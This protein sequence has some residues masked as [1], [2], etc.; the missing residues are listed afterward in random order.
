M[1]WDIAFKASLIICVGTILLLI[2]HIIPLSTN[3]ATILIGGSLFLY[4]L[5]FPILKGKQGVILDSSNN[6]KIKITFK[7]RDY[8]DLIVY[9]K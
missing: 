1:F 7:N 9:P 6:D 2:F 5:S 4:I 3:L 8:Y